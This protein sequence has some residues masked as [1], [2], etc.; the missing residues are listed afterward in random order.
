[1]VDVDQFL[2]THCGDEYSLTGTAYDE[3]VIFPHDNGYVAAVYQNNI[4]YGYIVQHPISLADCFNRCNIIASQC[5]NLTYAHRQSEWWKEAI[6]TDATPNQQQFLQKHNAFNN[7]MSKA[8]ACVAIRAIV[9]EQKQ[10]Q[11][12]GRIN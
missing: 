3:I 1:M 8:I 4:F 11:R 2:W 10:R 5:M 9:A 7:R 6:A 12:H